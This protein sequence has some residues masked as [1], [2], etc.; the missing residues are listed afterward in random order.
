MLAQF[1]ALLLL[2]TLACAAGLHVFAVGRATSARHRAYSPMCRQLFTPREPSVDSE[3]DG[4]VAKITD[5]GC[6]IRM[7]HEQHMGL[8]HISQLA[9]DNKIPRSEA[10]QFVESAT[11]PVGSKV[12]CSVLSTS[13]KGNKRISL[14]L[15]DVVQKQHMEDLVFARPERRR[16]ADDE[17]SE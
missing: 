17:T 5:Y 16:K 15:I 12:R 6:F 2:V 13:F 9:G 4:L 14:K 3:W 10:E 8:I 11:G 7:G 1:R